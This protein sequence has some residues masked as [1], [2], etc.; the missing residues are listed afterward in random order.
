MTDHL[1][2]LA[3]NPTRLT[4]EESHILLMQGVHPDI[5]DVLDDEFAIDDWAAVNV[6]QSQMDEEEYYAEP[7]PG[8][9]SDS[10]P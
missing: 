3:E 8:S 2:M 10:G 6:L 4:T 7:L 1:R 9:D 5:D